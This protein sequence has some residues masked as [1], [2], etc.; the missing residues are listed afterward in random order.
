MNG[1]ATKIKT[2]DTTY[3]RDTDEEAEETKPLAVTSSAAI[4]SEDASYSRDTDSEDDSKPSTVTSGEQGGAKRRRVDDHSREARDAAAALLDF[5]QTI[6]THLDNGGDDEEEITKMVEDNPSFVNAGCPQDIDDDERPIE[7]GCTAAEV[8]CMYDDT[9]ARDLL[10]ELV[11][12][13][14][15]GTDECYITLLKLMGPSGTPYDHF[16]VLL[17]SGHLLLEWCGAPTLDMF[18]EGL[19]NLEGDEEEPTCTL[20]MMSIL[21]KTLKLGDWIGCGDIDKKILI[22]NMKRLPSLEA[23]VTHAEGHDMDRLLERFPIGEVR[24]LLGLG[25]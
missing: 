20:E 18:L 2:E 21:Y 23:G 15:K 7:K 8:C 11:C 4:K 13:G 6:K 24:G 16:I 12:L 22:D 14:A 25:A 17:L 5:F 1:G 10:F 19:S 3:D 9:T